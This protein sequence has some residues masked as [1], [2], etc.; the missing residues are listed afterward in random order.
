[1]LSEIALFFASVLIVLMVFLSILY[2]FDANP[3][4]GNSSVVF[5]YLT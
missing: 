4:E 5:V 1:M 2:N 3:Y